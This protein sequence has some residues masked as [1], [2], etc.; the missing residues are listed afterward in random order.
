MVGGDWQPSYRWIFSDAWLSLPSPFVHCLLRVWTSMHQGLIQG[1]IQQEPALPEK[2]EKQPLM[3]SRHVHDSEG[4]QLGE[5]THIDWASWDR[6]LASSL[7]QW[8]MS[9]CLDADIIVQ[10][11]GITLG[12]RPS[13]A[14]LLVAISF[15]N[16]LAL[17]RP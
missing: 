1:L 8:S 4:R 2:F 10:E 5:R 14:F 17:G 12:G 9:R 11:H 3:W 6:G 13:S 7:L 15:I 16:V